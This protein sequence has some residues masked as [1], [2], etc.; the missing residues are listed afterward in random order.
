MKRH[1]NVIWLILVACFM[2]FMLAFPGWLSRELIAGLLSELGAM[3]LIGYVLVSLLRPL[4]LMPST[5]FILAGV[6]LFPQWL[7]L[8]LVISLVGVVV[9]A[10]LVYSFPSI[11]SYDHILERKFPSKIALLKQKMQHKHAFWF[12][13]GW[14]FFPLVPTDAVC[15]VAGVAKM[16][17]NKM[18]TALLIGEVPLVVMYVFVGSE[19]GEWLRV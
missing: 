4:L 10:Y 12:V 19:L 7:F 15:Y 11:G 5:P 1:I 6:I 13:V 8:V 16:S 3:A 14:S 2:G 18:I 9:G 17:F